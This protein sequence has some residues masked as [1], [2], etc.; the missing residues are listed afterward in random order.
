[1]AQ[2]SRHEN[3]NLFRGGIKGL[4][5]GAII[6]SL[7]PLIFLTIEMVKQGDGGSSSFAWFFGTAFG[8]GI[9]FFVGILTARRD[10]QRMS[11]AY[12]GRERRASMASY[13]GVDR[14]QHPG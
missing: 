1:M 11:Y 8:G 4:V 2:P 9:G 14:R 13:R 5:I 10:H 3:V 12:D 6:G 7:I